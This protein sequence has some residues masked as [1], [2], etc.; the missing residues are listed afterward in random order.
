MTTAFPLPL[1]LGCYTAGAGGRG[2]GVSVATESG[3]GRSAATA[4]GEQAPSPSCLAWHPN[5]RRLYAVSEQEDGAVCAFA[6]DQ[7]GEAPQLIGRL[8]VQGSAPCHLAVDPGGRWLVTANYSSG[9]VSVVALAA[10]GSLGALRHVLQHSGSGPRPDRQ[11]G[12]HPHM[13]CFVGD[14]L[15]VPDLGTDAVVAYRLDRERGVLV[16]STSTQLPPGFGPRHLA[17][18]PGNTIALVG[19]L[20]GELALLRLDPASGSLELLESQPLSRAGAPNLPSG[21][22]WFAGGGVVVANRGPDTLT[23]FLFRSGDSNAAPTLQRVGE[24]GCGGQNPR[25][26][27]ILDELVMV[28]NQDSDSV[29]LLR[30]DSASGRLSDTG[31][32][33]ATPSPAHILLGPNDS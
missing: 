16:A 31:E 22:A 2:R 21:I 27:T 3:R 8:A 1:Y 12:P 25:D 4:P 7:A 26:L 11:A 9:S 20:S 15:L 32:R 6:V 18:L 14:V 19:E 10:D 17:V 30:V 29:S 33:L 5:G 13:V 24:I 28:A 23:S